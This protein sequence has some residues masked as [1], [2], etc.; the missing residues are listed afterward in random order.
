M[1]GPQGTSGYSGPATNPDE[2]LFHE[3]IHT[4][5]QMRGGGASG[6]DQSDL[7]VVLTNVYL[8]EKKHR[9]LRALMF[10]MRSLTG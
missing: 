4:A 6:V 8:A 1:W 2:I 7:A 5:I 10:L 3:M 9:N